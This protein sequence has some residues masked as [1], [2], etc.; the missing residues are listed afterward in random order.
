MAVP[1]NHENFISGDKGKELLLADSEASAE[2]G[3]L[4]PRE[5]L[6]NQIIGGRIAK[7]WSQADLARA[8]GV[9]RPVVSRLESGTT[10]PRW[11]TIVKV[12]QALDLA[13]NAHDGAKSE[14]LAG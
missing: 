4:A 9:T 12:F 14:R 11:S 2:Y 13:L 8:L 6:I 10:D 7:G 1:R 3:R 5:R